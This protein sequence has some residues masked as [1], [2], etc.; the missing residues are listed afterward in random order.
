M[1]I[2]RLLLTSAIVD[3]GTSSLATSEDVTLIWSSSAA[4]VS[5]H[6][7]TVGVCCKFAIYLYNLIGKVLIWEIQTSMVTTT[8]SLVRF[9]LVD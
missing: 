8:S 6:S 9:G 5:L 1:K 2:F 3:V 7:N 4:A